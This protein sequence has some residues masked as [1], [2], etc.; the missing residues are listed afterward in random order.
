MTPAARLP[1]LDVLRGIAILGTLATNVW[2]FMHPAGLWG[3]IYGPRPD[4]L[5]ENVLRQLSTGKFLG[6]LSLLFGIGLAIQ[7]RAAAQAGQ[8][9]PDGYAWRAAL[10][11]LDGVLNYYLV[12]EFDVL[13]G[14]AISGLAVAWLLRAS[15]RSQRRWI[16]AL[17]MVHALVLTLFAF[18]LSTLPLAD[19]A[20]SADAF[21]GAMAWIRTGTVRGGISC[22]SV[23]HTFS[24]SV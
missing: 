14:Y 18:A 12:I 13:M 1:A 19:A 4:G 11:F 16:W 2:V 10:L 7:Q 9:W 6:L 3:E 21:A 5:L 23:M 17:A 15:D 22:D 24:I 20:T 8:R